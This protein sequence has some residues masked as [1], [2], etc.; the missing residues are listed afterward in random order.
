MAYGPFK[1]MPRSVK[2]HEYCMCYTVYN[3]YTAETQS[4]EG[5][6]KDSLSKFAVLCSNR[7][8]GAAA[9]SEPQPLVSLAM[10]FKQLKS[11]RGTHVRKR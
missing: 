1:T 9:P 7:C 8:K 3:N 6:K 2:S 10:W 5:T 11:T 4:L